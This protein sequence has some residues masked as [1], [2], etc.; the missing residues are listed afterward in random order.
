MPEDILEQCDINTLPDN[1]YKEISFY[2]RNGFILLIY[3]SKIINIDEYDDSNSIED[4]MDDLTFCGFI[5]L[6]NNLKNE[7]SLV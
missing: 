3:A 4:Y 7:V 1:F 2:R 6:K 5:T